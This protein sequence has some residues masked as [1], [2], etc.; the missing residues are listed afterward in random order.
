MRIIVAGAGHGGLCAAIHLARAGYPVT[1]LEKNTREQAGLPQVDAFDADA[2]A[3]AGLPVPEDFPRGSNQITFVPLEKDVAPLTLPRNPVESIIIDRKRLLNY[4]LDLA[5]EAGADLRF[6]VEIK[7]ALML[8]NRVAGVET[9]QGNAYGD[10]IIDACGVHSPVRTSL[11][12]HL[13]VDRAI[14][15][16]D[17]LHAYR[18]YFAL[19]ASKPMPAT[20][21]NIYIRDNGTVGFCWAI[22]GE[23][24]VDV[25]IARFP[26]MTFEDVLKTLISLKDDNP[27]ME[28]DNLKEGSFHDIPVAQPL[29]VPVADGYAAVGDSAFM[30]YSVKGSGIAYSLMAG[31]M[32]AETVMADRSGFFTAETLWP[33]ANRFFRQIGHSACLLALLK[34]LLPFLTA[35]EVNELIKSGFVTTEELENL[36]DNKLDAVLNVKGFAALKD[37][38]KTFSGSP[39]KN[40]LL[41]LLVWS[42]KL[43]LTEALMPL[44]YNRAEVARWAEKYNEFF[45]SIGKKEETPA[46][47]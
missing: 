12:A 15:P 17:V 21:Y 28:I 9:D 10:L 2:M 19:D 1:V 46:E 29:A 32:L 36:M 39:F 11:P 31:K 38:V 43:T 44:E 13:H 42:G 23:S 37:K 34:N 20:P 3:F 45:A 16:Y 26:E 35:Q 40:K 22:T 25:L 8:G 6:G 27:Q 47:G 30:T 7:R 14:G 4:L 41:E 18:G 24:D 5:Q 33:Y